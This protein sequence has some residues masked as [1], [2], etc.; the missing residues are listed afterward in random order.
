MALTPHGIEYPLNVV[1]PVHFLV[2]QCQANGAAAMPAS[3][4]TGFRLERSVQGRPLLVD[5]CHAQAPDKVGNEA[6]CMP[7]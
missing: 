1:K 2:C 5:L 7:G 3:G 4:L 6:G